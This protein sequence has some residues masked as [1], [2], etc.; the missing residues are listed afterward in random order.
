LSDT[1]SY[2][3]GLVDS[4][5]PEAV[6]EPGK[7]TFKISARSGRGK[8]TV[9]VEKEQLFQIGMS[10]K[11]FVAARPPVRDPAQFAAGAAPSRPVAL[12]FK[13]GDMSLRHDAASDVFT[14]SA[15]NVSEDEE[16]TGGRPEGADRPEEAVEVLFSLPRAGAERLADQALEV[17]A[18]GRKPCPLCGAPLDRGGHFCVKRNG[19]RKRDG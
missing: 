3:L 18:G 15:S 2:D 1:V 10:I 8:A 5:A 13:A 7:R 11:Q 16:Q 12:E 14:L 9:W 19:H 4:A 6:G 17:V